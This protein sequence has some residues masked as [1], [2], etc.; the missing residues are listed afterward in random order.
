MNELF[1][2]SNISKTLFA[3]AATLVVTVSAHALEINTSDTYGEKANQTELVVKSAKNWN[4]NMVQENPDLRSAVDHHLERIGFENSPAS[5]EKIS[6]LLNSIA[7]FESDFNANAKNPDSTASGLYQYVDAAKETAVNR[8]NNLKNDGVNLSPSLMDNMKS[9]KSGNM[10][11]DSLSNDDI[12]ALAFIDNMQR[13]GSDAALTKILSNSDP[14]AMADG[15]MDFYQV[16]HTNVN[17][18]NGS[19]ENITKKKAEVI[20]NLLSVQSDHGNNDQQKL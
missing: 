5:Y 19:L 10:D 15:V 11:F 3:I 9:I 13:K 4:I 12:S 7:F 14:M 16:H 6:I 17:L 20:F 2:S 8:V 1:S 18:E